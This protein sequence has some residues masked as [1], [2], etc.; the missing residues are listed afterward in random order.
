MGKIWRA[1]Y[2]N[3]DI[4]SVEKPEF[5]RL[6]E[7]MIVDEADL[8]LNSLIT[9]DKNSALLNGLYHLKDAQKTIYLS[10]TVDQSFKDLIKQCFADPVIEKFKS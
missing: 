3:L 1:G 9:F 10:A 6:N 8:T 2:K 7:V 5:I 4:S